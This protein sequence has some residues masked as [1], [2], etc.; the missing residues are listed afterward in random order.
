MAKD[1]GRW[2]EYQ[3]TGKYPPYKRKDG[4]Y[5][6]QPTAKEVAAKKAEEDAKKAE[7]AAKAPGPTLFDDDTPVISSA[8]LKTA[9]KTYT[10]CG[11]MGGHE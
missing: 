7:E 1:W 6:G 5:S 9:A 2:E 10:G 8:Q 11:C 3:R 4:T